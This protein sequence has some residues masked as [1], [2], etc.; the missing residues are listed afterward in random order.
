M[1]LLVLQQ[2]G[3]GQSSSYILLNCRLHWLQRSPAL[4]GQQD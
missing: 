1:R 4:D 3:L 2:L